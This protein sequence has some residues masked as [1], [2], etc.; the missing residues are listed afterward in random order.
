MNGYRC[1]REMEKNFR[2][3]SGRS[4]TRSYAR[5]LAAVEEIRVSVHA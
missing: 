3:A 1:K 4:E 2:K 5:D